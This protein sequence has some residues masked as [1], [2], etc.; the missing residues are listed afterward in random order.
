MSDELPYMSRMGADVVFG[1]ITG[2]LWG[3]T[4]YFIRKMF[5]PRVSW[6][7]MKVLHRNEAITGS[8]GVIVLVILQSLVKEYIIDD[9]LKESKKQIQQSQQ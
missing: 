6:E 4:Y 2:L 1:F 9:I 3:L 8:I 5:N 7:D